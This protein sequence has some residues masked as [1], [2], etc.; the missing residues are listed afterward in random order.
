MKGMCGIEHYL[1]PLG[2][3]V[4]AAYPGRRPADA[5]LTL[6]YIIQALWASE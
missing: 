3:H 6:G 2:L 1:T 4:V 5:G